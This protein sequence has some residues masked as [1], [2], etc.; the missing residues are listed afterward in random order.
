MMRILTVGW[1]DAGLDSVGLSR[2]QGGSAAPAVAE[3]A[4]EVARVAV[5]SLP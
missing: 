4:A 3:A 1:G 5:S 2:E